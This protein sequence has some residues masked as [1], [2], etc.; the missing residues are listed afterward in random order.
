MD[1]A[2]EPKVTIPIN[3]TATVTAMSSQCSQNRKTQSLPAIWIS[4]AS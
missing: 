4:P 3:A 2:N 1:P